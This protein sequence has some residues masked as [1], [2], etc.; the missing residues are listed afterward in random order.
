MGIFWKDLQVVK[1]VLFTLAWAYVCLFAG[2]S[3]GA[4]YSPRVGAEHADFV[5]PSIVDGAPVSLSQYRG[6]KV[7]LV[8]FASW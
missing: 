5:L 4:G 6:R 8:H 2:M 3:A 1:S 7:L